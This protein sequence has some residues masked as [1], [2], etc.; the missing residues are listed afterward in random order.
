MALYIEK[1]FPEWAGVTIGYWELLEVC[2]YRLSK[3]CEITLGGWINKAA[4][5]SQPIDG[6]MATKEITLPIF[7]G[8]TFNNFMSTN[9]EAIQDINLAIANLIKTVEGWETLEIV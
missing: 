4:F 8:D 7:S 3:R 6:K 1:T 9:A 5:D 2:F